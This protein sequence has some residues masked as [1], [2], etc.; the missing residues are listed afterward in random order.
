[1]TPEQVVQE[2]FEAYN[3]HDLERFLAVF[4]EDACL[5][6]PPATE[7][8]LAGREALAAFYAGERF[9]HPALRAELIHRIVL[10]GRVI[11]HE[12]LHGL[13]DAPIE[14]AMVYEVEG[15]LIQRAWP[16]TAT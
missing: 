9:C 3:A 15:G 4:A 8:A 7:P 14:M 5:F 11:D 10:G 12:R 13:G 2:Q 1:M 6:R 16:F